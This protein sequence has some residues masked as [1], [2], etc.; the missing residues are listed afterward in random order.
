MSSTHPCPACPLPEAVLACRTSAAV[1][2]KWH[3]PHTATDLADIMAKRT[4][5]SSC[6][7]SWLQH[8]CL[9]MLCSGLRMC[10]YPHRVRMCACV[11]ALCACLFQVCARLEPR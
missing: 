7:V 8:P 3:V 9:A 1:G 4:S 6:R 10:A 11:C 2:G 5:T